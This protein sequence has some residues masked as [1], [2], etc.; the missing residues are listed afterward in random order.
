MK[1]LK[2]RKA[3]VVVVTGGAAG[4]G[5]SIAHAFAK[6][7]GTVVLID[8]NKAKA[9]QVVR[10]M[11]KKGWLAEAASADLSVDGAAAAVIRKIAKKH[12]RLDVLINNAGSKT[13]M[14]FESETEK[15]W[16]EAMNVML[17]SVFFASREA[18]RAMKD[19]GGGSI[20]NIGSVAGRMVCHQPPAY[21]AAKAALEQLTKYLACTAG[22]AQVRVNAIIPGFIVKEEHQAR[23][24]APG[25]NRYREAAEFSHPLGRVGTAEDVAKAALFLA[26]TTNTY[27]SGHCLVLD[28]GSQAYEPSG[29]IIKHSEKIL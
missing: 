1:T 11:R 9:E 19:N 27:L 29:L 16:D 28:G 26:D 20:I 8:K 22:A 17:K 6:A 13:G 2:G 23:F 14:D 10:E 24:Y 5:L 18:I 25:N 7:G 4:I 21:H 12:Q 15:S 3:R